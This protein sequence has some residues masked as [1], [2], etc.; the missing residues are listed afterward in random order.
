MA[1]IRIECL[2]EDKEF[3][4]EALSSQCWGED[5]CRFSDF[6]CNENCHECAK[7]NVEFVIKE[8][9]E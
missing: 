3:I 2:E 7:N 8:D 4:I 5:D 9:E 6:E 1:R